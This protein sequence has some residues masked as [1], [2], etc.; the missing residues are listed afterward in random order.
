M[1]DLYLYAMVYDLKAKKDGVI[2]IRTFVCNLR[3]SLPG[4][5][6][7]FREYLHENENIFENILGC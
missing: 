7:Y 6:K 1:V 3:V 5:C 4:G 2:Y